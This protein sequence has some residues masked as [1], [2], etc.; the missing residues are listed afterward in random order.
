MFNEIMRVITGR[1]AERRIHDRKKVRF[2]VRV[3]IPDQPT[4]PGVGI[5]ISESGFSFV[6]KDVPNVPEL[7]VQIDLPARSIRARVKVSRNDAVIQN[8]VEW[9][10][11]A[12][13]FVG[14]PA[15]DWDAVYRF[16]NDTAE[17]DNKG[18]DELKN[19]LS[20]DDD[21]YRLLPLQ[22]QKIIVQHL[23]DAHRLIEPG[24][25]GTP[26]LKMSYLGSVRKSSDYQVHRFKV[27]SRVKVQDEMMQYD[28]FFTVDDSGNVTLDEKRR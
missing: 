4:L 14:I 28:T 22:T 25:G 23:I 3:I 9:K 2:P 11:L 19:K 24:H 5:E 17:P 16:I 13:A 21:A 7:N 1:G 20:Q 10:M 26:L 12:V 6:G 27:H 18:H 8:G 15:D